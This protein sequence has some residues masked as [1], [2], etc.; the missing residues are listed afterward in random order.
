M[1]T[2]D[3][4]QFRSLWRNADE[5]MQLHDR[6]QVV[7]RLR[8]VSSFDGLGHLLDAILP[9]D[10]SAVAELSP[11]LRVTIPPLTFAKHN[12]K[13]ETTQRIM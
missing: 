8:D 1:T 2:F 7:L 6:L 10:P 11:R 3:E 12:L 4:A 5:A 13:P 9:D